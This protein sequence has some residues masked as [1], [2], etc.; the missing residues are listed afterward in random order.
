MAPGTGFARF[1]IASK[2]VQRGGLVAANGTG[3]EGGLKNEER[4]WTGKLQ[5][6]AEKQERAAES[7]KRDT[8]GPVGIDR[9][10][11]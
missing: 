3:R 9:S 10:S 11:A 2:S 4:G 5:K 8:P 1:R 7:V 6:S